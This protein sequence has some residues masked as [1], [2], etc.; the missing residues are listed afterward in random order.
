MN[1]SD[2]FN[3]KKCSESVKGCPCW[4]ELIETN[5]QTGED[6]ITKDCLYKLLPHL[7]VEVIKAS[8]RPAAAVETMRNNLIENLSRG[9]SALVN[10][11]EVKSLPKPED[12][13]HHV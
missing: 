5:I 3:C 7:L 1:Y 2:A 6:R 9:F 12:D 10:A 8:N 13:N 11:V 4:T